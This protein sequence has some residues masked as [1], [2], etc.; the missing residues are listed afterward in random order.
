MTLIDA[1]FVIL[2]RRIGV[3][4]VEMR[5]VYSFPFAPSYSV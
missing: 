2:A 5:L 1:F 3:E 4:E